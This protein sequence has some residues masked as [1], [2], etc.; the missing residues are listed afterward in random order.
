M[1]YQIIGLKRMIKRI[2]RLLLL[3]LKNKPQISVLLTLSVSI[4]LTA[5]GLRPQTPT[6]APPL[7]GF[8]TK[9]PVAYF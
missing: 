7:A 3:V 9:S 6:D 4:I 5:L 8:N 1:D 2:K